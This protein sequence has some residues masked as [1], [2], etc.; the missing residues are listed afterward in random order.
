MGAVEE[1]IADLVPDGEDPRVFHRVPSDDACA[2]DYYLLATPGQ[3]AA[4]RDAFGLRIEVR[5][6]DGLPVR[7]R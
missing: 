1:G 7:E 3:A 5:G 2:D 6:P 4:L